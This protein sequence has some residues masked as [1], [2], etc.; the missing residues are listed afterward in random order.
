MAKG[1]HSTGDIL[2]KTVDGTD[3]NKLWDDYAAALGLYNAQRQPLIDLLSHSVT[4]IVEDVVLP[5]TERFEEASEFGVPKAIRPTVTS[6]KRAYPFKWYDLRAG[7][8]WQFLT[9]ASQKQLDQVLNQAMEAEN[10]LI[11]DQVM[12]SLFNDANRVA[13]IDDVPYTVTALYNGSGTQNIPPYQGQTFPNN[14]THYLTSG[15]ALLDSKDLEDLAATVEHH[16]YTTGNG[17]NIIFLVNPADATTIS[18]FRRGVANNNAVVATYDWLPNQGVN[19]LLPPGWSAAGSLVGD[20][21]AGM[22]VAGSYGPY[23]I[24]KNYSIPV[25]YVVAA[26]SQGRSSTLNIVGIR[27]DERPELRGLIIMPGQSDAYP[28]RNSYFVRGLG[29]GVSQRGAAAI[30]QITANAS[31]A[32][33]AAYVW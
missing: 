18:G 25:G 26:A 33:P 1:F 29:A 5:G 20:T 19:F 4:G 14:H 23:L 15:A 28:L 3:F 8:T 30:M 31:Y 17:Y 11:F 2:T 32:V 22:D 9:K 27:E 7:Y 24:V 6:V 13:T 21:F 10:A 16:G 12:K